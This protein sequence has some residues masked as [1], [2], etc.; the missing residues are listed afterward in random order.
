[1]SREKGRKRSSTSWTLDELHSLP[2]DGNKYEVV[3]GVLFVTPA[4]TW[5]HESILAAEA[6]EAL[7]IKL[8][9]IFFD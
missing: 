6:A 9:D 5:Q 1:M 3:R 7:E 4:P 2:D 8:S